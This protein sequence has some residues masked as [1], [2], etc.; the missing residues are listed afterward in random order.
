MVCAS[1]WTFVSQ[2]T[3]L[4]FR[5]Q[6]LSAKAFLIALVLAVILVGAVY[7]LRRETPPE[8]AR[9]PATAEARLERGR[10]LA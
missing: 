3:N 10:A 5:S 7:D 8:P 4:G 6:T 9:A 2:A 1:Q